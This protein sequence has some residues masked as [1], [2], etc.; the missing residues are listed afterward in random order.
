MEL[1]EELRK[2]AKMVIGVLTGNGPTEFR[3]LR[4]VAKKY[5]GSE[6]VLY[7]PR[8]PGYHPGS[9]LSVL[10]VT[11]I[12][13]D[14]YNIKK[15]LCLIDKEHISTKAAVERK[16]EEKLREFGVEVNNIQKLPANGEKALR[17]EGTIGSHNFVLLVAITGRIKYIEEDIAKLIGIK[18]E[19]A[20]V[21]P[22][23][24]GVAKALKKHNIDLEQLV[25]NANIGEL[26][27]S[28]P[29]LNSVLKHLESDN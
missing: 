27:E 20:E 28:F 10:K 19:E 4:V 24:N 7:F 12:H 17:I 26:K 22:T 25:K 1:V 2:P 6:K 15:F 3:V 14:K 21:E 9:G 11:K 5:N 13:V 29:A 23:K 16:I 8:R 18:I